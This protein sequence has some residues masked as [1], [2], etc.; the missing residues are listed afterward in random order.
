MLTG[1]LVDQRQELD[2]PS[3]SHGMFNRHAALHE[4]LEVS[5]AQ[6]IDSIPADSGR[7]DIGRKTHSF[8]AEHGKSTN[9][10]DISVFHPPSVLVNATQLVVSLMQ[11]RWCTCKKARLEKP[12]EGAG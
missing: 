5:V 12:G 9:F 11:R 4:L 1:Q 2:G 6:R 7:D 3:V 8:E 10:G